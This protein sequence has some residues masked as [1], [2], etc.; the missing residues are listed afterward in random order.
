MPLLFSTQYLQLPLALSGKGNFHACELYSFL[1]KL[2]KNSPPLLASNSKIDYKMKPMSA[3]V[4]KMHLSSGNLT[5]AAAASAVGQGRLLL[6]SSILFHFRQHL[7][8]LTPQLHFFPCSIRQISFLGLN[9]I[10]QS[11]MD[12]L[13]ILS[14]GK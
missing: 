5:F 12:E 4:L 3:K 9:G 6:A 7:L 8:C 13:N 2:S 14:F 10:Q 11:F 1:K